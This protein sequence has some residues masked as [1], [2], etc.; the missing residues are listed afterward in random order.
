MV[1]QSEDEQ[2]DSRFL[3]QQE[4]LAIYCD[5]YA[6]D[7]A[8]IKRDPALLDYIVSHQRILDELI[9]GYTEMGPINRQICDE[10]VDCECDDENKNS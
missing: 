10:F 7:Q 1:Y 5:Y 6:I 4:R 2:F 9:S 3:K 8:E